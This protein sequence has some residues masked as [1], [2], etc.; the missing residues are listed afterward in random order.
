MR[1][2]EERRK[3]GRREREG[4]REGREQRERRGGRGREGEGENRG[5]EEEREGEKGMKELLNI[6][7]PKNQVRRM[8]LFLHTQ[9]R[10]LSLK[11]KT[12]FAILIF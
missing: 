7:C 12:I 4:E 9:S 11:I 5:R 10:F 1:E 6:R 8:R 3:E 2:G